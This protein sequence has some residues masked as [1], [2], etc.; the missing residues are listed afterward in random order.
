M[1]KSNEDSKRCR[2]TEIVRITDER[3]RCNKRIAVMK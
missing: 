2:E 1:A 3:E